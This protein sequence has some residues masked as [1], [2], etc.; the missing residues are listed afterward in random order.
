MAMA[1]PPPCS[2]RQALSF[3][4][5][6]ATVHGAPCHNRWRVVETS[7]PARPAGE[8]AREKRNSLWACSAERAT[9]P[10]NSVSEGRWRGT[11]CDIHRYVRV[12]LFFGLP[13]V[14]S[15]V[16]CRGFCSRVPF[17]LCSRHSSATQK[18]LHP[19]VGCLLSVLA[20][21]GVAPFL[22]TH[23]A[24]WDAAR[25]HCTSAR[26]TRN[27]RPSVHP[28]PH[29]QTP[30][31]EHPTTR[32]RASRIGAVHNPSPQGAATPGPSASGGPPLVARAPPVGSSPAT[33]P[34]PIPPP[35]PRPCRRHDY[36]KP[37]HFECSTGF[38]N[39]HCGS[40]RCSIT[41]RRETAG[42]RRCGRAR[43]EPSLP[44][45]PLRPN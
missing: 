23:S 42:V 40:R 44:R 41:F 18:S 29:Q 8:S 7:L 16:I 6:S 37:V 20:A 39:P 36:L 15:H 30:T 10:K 4:P 2:A 43:R 21:A 9:N 5:C 14:P 22:L 17:L 28:P 34:P 3:A 12:L 31:P 33:P 11:L 38:C 27:R 26:C 45:P 13:P 25:D 1:A 35:V 32:N 19:V 24:V